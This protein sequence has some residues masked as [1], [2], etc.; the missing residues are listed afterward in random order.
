MKFSN[1]IF[2]ATS[3]VL[4]YQIVKNRQKIKE[5]IQ[6]TTD[7]FSKIQTDLASI[8]YN[9]DIIEEQSEKATKIFQ[10]ISYQYKVLENQ[11]TKQI[12]QIKEIWQ[13]Y[14]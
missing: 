5:E 11:A 2:F 14:N 4:S 10:D 9:T 12:D 13:N 8:Q 6:E 3:A 1:F 7:A